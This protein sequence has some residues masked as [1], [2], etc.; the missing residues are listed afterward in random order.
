MKKKDNSELTLQLV[1]NTDILSTVAASGKASFVVG[2]AA[3]TEHVVQYATRK[4]KLKNW[5]W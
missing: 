2:F 4:I 3:E 5:I 1:R